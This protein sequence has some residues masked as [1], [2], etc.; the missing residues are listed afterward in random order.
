MSLFLHTSLSLQICLFTHILVLTNMSLSLHNV[1]V[2][3]Y[4]SLSLNICPI[5]YTHL[6]VFKYMSL[7]LNICPVIYTHLLVFTY[8]SLSLSYT[9]SL[10]AP[11][12][13]T[14]KQRPTE[15]QSYN[16]LQHSSLVNIFEKQLILIKKEETFL[17]MVN[18]V[19]CLPVLDM[20]RETHFW[21]R[22]YPQRFLR[23]P[24]TSHFPSRVHT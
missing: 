2:F 11:G 13:S 12:H 8:M 21:Y 14:S 7:S 17:C 1:H 18:R 3:K 24:V 10:T 15:W 9:P 4:T 23:S 16:M 5:F 22:Q 20:P 6:L 19:T